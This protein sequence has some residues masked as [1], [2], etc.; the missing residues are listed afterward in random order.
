MLQALQP[1]KA[2]RPPGAVRYTLFMQFKVD[3]II[4]NYVDIT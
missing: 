4:L 2:G 3:N 1:K